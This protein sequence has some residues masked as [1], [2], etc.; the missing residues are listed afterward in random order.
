[1]NS[2]AMHAESCNELTPIT[3]VLASSCRETQLYREE[4]VVTIEEK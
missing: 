3:T 1:M 2:I 4:L